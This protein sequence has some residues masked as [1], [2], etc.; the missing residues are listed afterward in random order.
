MEEEN[1]RRVH[2][3]FLRV[4]S[5][6]RRDD[7]PSH[8]GTG[9]HFSNRVAR[10]RRARARCVLDL[11]ANGNAKTRNSYVHRCERRAGN[12]TLA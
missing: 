4:R 1:A 11:E 8:Q 7:A 2:V 5:S 3:Y 6:S 10:E 12:V 9:W